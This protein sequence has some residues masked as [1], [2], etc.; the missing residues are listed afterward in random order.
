VL[1]DR[2]GNVVVGGQGE[3]QLG[4]EV[5]RPRLGD[6]RA[7]QRASAFLRQRGEDRREDA[8][9]EVLLGDELGRQRQRR[10]WAGEGKLESRSRNINIEQV[11]TFSGDQ[12]CRPG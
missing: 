12:K 1:A 10:P 8:R 7:L 2:I 3:Q 4:V 9:C 5:V 11:T 6:G